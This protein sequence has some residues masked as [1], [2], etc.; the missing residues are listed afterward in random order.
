MMFEFNAPIDTNQMQAV[1][2]G[3]AQ[4]M[5]RW[6]DGPNGR[7]SSGEPLLDEATGAPVRVY[8][9]MLP[10]GRDGRHELHGVRIISHEAPEL[11]PYSQVELVGLV[12]KVRQARNGGK[13][14]DVQF[15]AEAIRPSGHQRSGGRRSAETA[16][17]A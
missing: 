14:V 11:A 16:E 4:T 13:G 7:R 12:A 9:V 10:T 1:A 5:E 15:N 3:H 8:D 6:E 2:T 17:A